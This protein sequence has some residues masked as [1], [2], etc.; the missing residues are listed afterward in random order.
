M[1][2]SAMPMRSEKSVVV[3][4]SGII[5]I[6]IGLALLEAGFG[7]RIIDRGR[8]SEN[9]SEGNA[10]AFALADIVPLATPGI[11]RTAPRWLIDPMGP[12]SIRPAYVFAIAPWLIKFWRASWRDKFPALMQAQSDLMA[13]S[14]SALDRQATLYHGES[15]LNRAGQLRLYDNRASFRKSASYWKACKMFGI[16]YNLLESHHEI[17]AIQPGLAKN[18]AYA[19]FTPDWVNVVDPKLWLKHLRDQFISGGG[20]IEQKEARS[21]SVTAHKAMILCDGEQISSDHVVVAAGAWSKS[22]AQAIGDKIPL[23]TE[24]GY[25]TTFDPGDFQLRTHLTFADHGFVVSKV[26]TRVRVGGAVEL[27][28]LNAP[29][30]F[31]RAR[32]LLSKAKQFLPNME[33]KQG[34]EWMGFRPSMPDSLPVI[35]PAPKHPRVIYAF[36]HGHLGLTQSAATAELVRNTILGKPWPIASAPFS[37]ERFVS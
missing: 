24:R 25:N 20:L 9:A 3:V 36:G 29:P 8:P 35:G 19:G 15:L 32:N 11:I 34:E 18:F 26:G 28:G 6:S 37:P 16:A 31:L 22:L 7:V 30:N 33:T 5:G 27:G 13:L 21:L 23:E 17:R 14:R 4:G 2:L 12:L 10:G 1:G